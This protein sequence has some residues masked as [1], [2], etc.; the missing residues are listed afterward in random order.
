MAG[1]SAIDILVIDNRWITQGNKKKSFSDIMTV[2]K[3]DQF[4][5]FKPN[6]LNNII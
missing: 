6:R 2:R 5:G 1:F 3:R 4:L